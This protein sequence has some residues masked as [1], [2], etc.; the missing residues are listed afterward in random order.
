MEY[1]IDFL[2][3]SITSPFLTLAAMLFWGEASV[4]IGRL[5]ADLEWYVTV[6]D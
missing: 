4:V 1:L 6:S 2:H 3:F 5:S